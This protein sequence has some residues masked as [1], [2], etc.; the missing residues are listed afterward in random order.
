MTDTP[1][2]DRAI[3]TAE[4]AVLGGSPELLHPWKREIARALIA[5]LLEGMDLNTWTATEENE[6]YNAALDAV[7]KRAGIES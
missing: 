7:R 3:R 1:H 5:S 6:G 2:L 4:I